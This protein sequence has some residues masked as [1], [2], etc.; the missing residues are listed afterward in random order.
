MKQKQLN[1]T[2]QSLIKSEEKFRT[3]FESSTDAV[4]IL[5]P[6]TGYID[7]NSAALKMFSVSSKEEMLKL[8]PAELLPKY[9]PGGKPS[10]ELV[11]KNIDKT[12]KDG[13]CIFEWYY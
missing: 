5:D 12:L 13:M 7:C 4:L 6:E 3:F 1:I 2:D 11:K 9:Q 10:L 8:N